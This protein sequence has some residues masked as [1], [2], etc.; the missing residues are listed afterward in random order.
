MN[1]DTD[2][3]GKPDIDIDT[4]GNGKPDIN[5][6]T[7]KDG[8]PDLNIDTDGDGKPDI[9]IDTDGDGIPDLN[10]DIDGD[11][12]PDTNIDTDGDGKPDENVKTP[13]EID[14][15]IKDNNKEDQNA[16]NKTNDD[17]E[18]ELPWWIPRTGDTSNML[19]WLAILATALLALTGMIACVEKKRESK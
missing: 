14:K 4:D 9:N 12:K 10:V 3:D 6:D 13:S 1:K 7:N 11:G 17:E 8:K 2:G 16:G 15:L 5:I 18:D 19:T